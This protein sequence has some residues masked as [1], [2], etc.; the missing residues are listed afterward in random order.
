MAEDDPAP[1]T[2][3]TVRR[4]RRW[5]A[6]GRV[7]GWMVVAGLVALAA[8]W[9]SRERIA[10]NVISGQLDSLGLPAKYDVAQIGTD[11]QVLANVVVG[12]PARPDL[13]VERV[14]VTL[15][16][17]FGAPAI[18]RITLVR[19]R[20][21]G[22]YF[23]GKLSFGSLDP[24]IFTGSKE[25]FRLPDLDI[26]VRDGRALLQSD[27]GDAGVKLEGEGN[28]RDGFAGYLAAV[29]P[30]ARLAGCTA[31]RA[32]LFADVR[33]AGEKP[34]LNGPLRLAGLDCPDSGI[35]LARGDVA[36]VATLDQPLD[37][38]EASFSLSA[39]S[40][41]YAGN[42]LNAAKGEGRLSLRKGD[43]TA[44]FALTGSGL[45]AGQLAA[46][47]VTLEGAL[48]SA[49]RFARIETEGTLGGTGLRPGPDL[50]AALVRVERAGGGTLV[51][52]IAARVR[53]ALQREGSGSRLTA[54]FILRRTGGVMTLV[55]PQ[56]ELHGAS[57]QALLSLSRLQ[58]LAGG[59]SP[60]RFSG[61]FA[62]GGRDMPRIAGRME[63]APGGR[64]A[65]RVQMPA[66]RAADASLA[67][68]LLSLTQGADGTLGFAGMAEVSGP[69]PGGSAQG[70]R[71][72]IEGA[73]SPSRGLAMWRKCIDVQFER[74]QLANLMLTRRSL[75]LCPAQG[76]AIVLA[77]GGGLKLAA[78]AP[79]LD[80]AGSLG[81]TPIRIASGP[82]GFAVPGVLAARRLDIALGP[83]RTASRFTIDRLDARIGRDIAGSFAGSEVRLNAVPLDLLDTAGKWRYANG[84]LTVSD[85][86]FRL[87]DRVELDRFQP[88]LASGATLTLANGRIDAEARLREATS[89][90][91]VMRA[92]IRHD[93]ASG[94]GDADLLVDAL[95][96][97]KALQPDMITRQALGVI[98]NVE[99]TLR[100]QGHIDWGGPAVV[101]NGTF[102]T[103]RLDFAAQ[104]GPVS[105]ASGKVVFTDLL[106]FVTAPNQVVRVE[107][108][109]PGIEVGNGSLRY[110]LQ[111][112]SVLA[113]HGGSWPFMGGTLTLR[114]AR[115][116]IGVAET[117]RYTLDIAGLDAAKL[118]AQMDMANLSATGVFDGSMPL[119]FDEQGGRIEGGQLRSRAPGGNVAYVG[120][121]TYKD[122]SAMANF[123][124]DALKSIDYREMRIDLDGSLAGEIVTRVSFDGLSQGKQARSNF[125][126]RQVAKLPLKFNVNIRAPFF[127]LVTSL[128]SIYDP[129]YVR[130]PRTLGMFRVQDGKLIRQPPRAVA[131]QA[132]IGPASAPVQPRES[133]DTP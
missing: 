119:V 113:I 65:L 31:T 110:E 49:D 120:Q 84:R 114:P 68:P 103:D 1:E 93:L 51:A 30:N 96:F 124:F 132:A 95:V 12:D 70:L 27:K 11:R 73:W 53:T 47:T 87:E 41:A 26:A 86:A 55:V 25:P 13:T 66:Y 126:T 112:G 50:D 111:P 4:K 133:G 18:D 79:R 57:G 118:L 32:S 45:G 89:G 16:P 75:P 105:G 46:R 107:S 38:G 60:A 37:G 115:M 5:R 58:L 99:G 43:L 56:G 106:N 77:D 127:Q 39:G 88:L 17:R 24:L 122:L 52:P 48:R 35:K 71:L 42:A 69:L 123:A 29:S 98:A 81:A 94:G 102:G 14:E 2:A 101:S 62:T 76:G 10:E 78:G 109:N 100:G 23:N 63:R 19:P 125:V 64:L 131:T 44:H 85:A 121:L 36:L 6:L 59:T 104:F 108:M 22:A 33:I 80:V 92:L 7:L 40:L 130:D 15:A 83:A 128:R 91:E 116:N 97:D 54:D 8:A 67:L 117:R 129:A 3:P 20:L 9:F 21:Y 72:P 28:L 90:R 34:K 82:V 61:N 74:L